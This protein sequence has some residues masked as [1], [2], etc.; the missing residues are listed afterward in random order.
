MY[1]AFAEE[2]CT[3]V[4]QSR[5]LLRALV[6]RG[7][8]LYLPLNDKETILHFLFDLPSS[9]NVINTLLQEP[10]VS[11]IDFNHRDQLGRT[12]LMAACRWEGSVP[13]YCEGRFKVPKT[14]GGPIRVLDHGVDATC[15]DED[16]KTALHHLLSNPAMPEEIVLEFI[17]R[18]EVAS[19]LWLKDND[20]FT[21]FHYALRTLRPAVCSWFLDKGSPASE[22]DPEGLTPLHHIATRCLQ[23]ERQLRKRLSCEE[24]PK[25]YFDQCLSLWQ[26]IITNGG[27]INAT[28]NAGNTSLHT[29]LLTP[30]RT[31]STHRHPEICHVEHF[32]KLFPPDSNVDVSAVNNAGETALHI[33]TAREKP[34]HNRMPN[35]DKM[36]FEMLLARGVDPLKED[37]KGR[38]ALDIAS[39]FGKDDIIA[40]MSRK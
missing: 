21:P 4:T 17:N 20:G 22:A 13:G 11:R 38:S 33:V 40:I 2:T 31:G 27:S 6:E 35:H 30:E 7:A 39:V 29:H 18:E 8:V 5:P 28:D 3:N 16:G 23:V 15:V 37:V 9:Y 24:L 12:V 10:C 32:D 19:T 26:K 1:A 34:L 25:D 14:K 36:L